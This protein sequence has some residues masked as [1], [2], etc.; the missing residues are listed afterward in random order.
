MKMRLGF[1]SNSSSSSFVIPLSVLTAE[2]LAMILNHIE[3]ARGFNMIDINEY[4]G[5]DISVNNIEVE[6]FTFMDNFDMEAFLQKI[7]VDT[8]KVIFEGDNYRS[9]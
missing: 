1:V 7:G 6:G 8:D 9:Y 3:V 4:D 5:W 2:Q